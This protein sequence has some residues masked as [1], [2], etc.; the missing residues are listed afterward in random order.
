MRFPCPPPPKKKKLSIAIDQIA[1][2]PRSKK[3]RKP[4]P[5]S[6]LSAK[7][8]ALLRSGAESVF[9]DLSGVGFK[10]LLLQAVNLGERE[11]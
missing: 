1:M 5:P 11:V 8:K 7:C 4:E 10:H 3:A 2:P 6:G 9:G